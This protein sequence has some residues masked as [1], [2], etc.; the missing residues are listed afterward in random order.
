MD[1]RD[2]KPDNPRFCGD[3]LASWNPHSPYLSHWRAEYSAAEGYEIYIEYSTNGD[4]FAQWDWDADA[5]MTDYLP[6]QGDL[7]EYYPEYNS[8]SYW[9]MRGCAVAIT[10]DGD[11]MVAGTARL[12]MSGAEPSAYIEEDYQLFLAVFNETDIDGPYNTGGA[13]HGISSKRINWVDQQWWL[14]GTPIYAEG[15]SLR[16]WASGTCLPSGAFVV[17]GTQRR[18][19][20]FPI[21]W[22]AY[23]CY[24]PDETLFDSSEASEEHI[25]R[26]SNVPGSLRVSYMP[27]SESF[28]VILPSSITGAVSLELFDL[29]GRMVGC[30]CIESNMGSPVNVPLSSFSSVQLPAGVYVVLFRSG[31]VTNTCHSVVIR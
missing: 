1:N 26:E 4:C 13:R 31:G 9:G 24:M 14:F 25:C 3:E 17:V 27:A 19:N 15:V 21:T 16:K 20:Q 6:D 2:L 8:L 23:V 22:K 11:Y 5:W 30:T 12:D 10:D 29:S 28:C 18:I 7:D